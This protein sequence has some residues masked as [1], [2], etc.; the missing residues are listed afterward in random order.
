MVIK[1]NYDIVE[2]SA[3]NLTLLVLGWPLGS[4]Y[5]YSLVF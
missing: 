2:I 4:L 5:K 1:H 3:G